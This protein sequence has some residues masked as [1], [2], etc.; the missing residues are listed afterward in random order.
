MSLTTFHSVVVAVER[1][2]KKRKWKEV[3]FNRYLNINWQGAHDSSHHG[4]AYAGIYLGDPDIGEL[5]ISEMSPEDIRAEL[6]R[7]FFRSLLTFVDLIFCFSISFLYITS[8]DQVFLSIF[9][10]SFASI[11]V[12]SICSFR[13]YF[14]FHLI[15]LL[16]IFFVCLF[17]SFFSFFSLSSI[18]RVG[19][20]Y[21]DW[22]YNRCCSIKDCTHNSK[23]WKIKRF[24]RTI[25]ILVSVEVAVSQ[26]IA[27]FRC[28]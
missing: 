23:Y 6:K 28:R 14:S 4:G 24:D 21:V 17:L 2:K 5:T 13:L 16:V 11:E 3:A 15:W 12:H 7:Y 19:F 18:C 25:H 20:W 27:D 10:F 1:E 22:Y 9:V 26:P 8:V